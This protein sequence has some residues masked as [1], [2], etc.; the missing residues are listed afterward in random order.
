MAR[1]LTTCR[2]ASGLIKF[3]IPLILGNMFQQLYNLVDTI[4]VGNYCGRHA[5]AAVGA[6]A[7]VTTLFICI[8]VG[9]GIGAS[10]IIAQMYGARKYGRMMTAIKTACTVFFIIG[11]VLM[12][13][14][15]KRVSM[16]I[17]LI[18]CAVVM[19]SEFVIIIFNIV[20]TEQTNVQKALKGGCL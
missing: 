11:A 13:L 10:V 20:R 15:W 17:C 6:S 9:G 12:A 1:D 18:V 19:I 3:A 8:S 5:L 4:V 14:L 16:K 7:P 2:P